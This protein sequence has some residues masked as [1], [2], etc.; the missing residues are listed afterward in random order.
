VIP[1]RHVVVAAGVWTNALTGKIGVYYPYETTNHKVVH[2]SFDEDYSADR[3]PM[4]RDLPGLCY[5]RPHD[6]GMLLGVQIGTN[7]SAC[8]IP[9]SWPK[10]TPA[11]S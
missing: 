7:R 11:G 3:Y 4:V 1:A 8:S 5:N 10:P 6:G 9:R 2:F